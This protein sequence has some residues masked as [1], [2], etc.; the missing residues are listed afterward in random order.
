V[1]VTAI[2]ETP[3]NAPSLAY[4]PRASAAGQASNLATVQHGDAA[5]ICVSGATTLN[6]PPS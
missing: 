3:P 6:Q 2:Y 5:T 4:Y 1:P